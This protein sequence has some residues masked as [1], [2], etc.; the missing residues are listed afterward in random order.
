[1]ATEVD[2]CNLALSRAKAGSIG[3]LQEVSPQADQC[4]I[5]YGI[6]RDAVLAEFAWHFAKKT[7]ALSL[8]EVVPDEW[9][10]AYDYPNDCEKINYLFPVG[11]VSYQYV[12]AQAIKYEISSVG[13]SKLI[14]TNTENVGAS[15]TKLVTDTGLFTQKFIQLVAW[16]LA[17]DLAISLGGDSG[18]RLSE[19]ALKMYEMKLGVAKAHDANE[20]N[21]QPEYIP[22]SIRARHSSSSHSDIPKE[23]L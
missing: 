21:N 11:V 9:L 6:T 16:L 8:K 5:L 22:K 20:Q 15:Y 2:I 10:Y 19:K 18:Q 4:R 14:L 3:S 1:M 12:K 7:R 23:A 17:S 13:S